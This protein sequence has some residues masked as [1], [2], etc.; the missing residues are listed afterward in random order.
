MVYRRSSSTAV[1]GVGETRRRQ[2]VSEGAWADSPRSPRN[3]PVYPRKCKLELAGWR[4]EYII[5][6]QGRLYLLHESTRRIAK[7]AP[8]PTRAFAEYPLL[9]PE[10]RMS[11]LAELSDIEIESFRCVALCE[12]IQC[13]V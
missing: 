2:C 8:Y 6:T 9:R 7:S 5:Y 11:C 10:I 12:A 4:A 1:E 3:R 13:T